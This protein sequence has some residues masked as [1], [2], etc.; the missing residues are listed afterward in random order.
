M[1]D[2][3]KNRFFRSFSSRATQNLQG[4][5]IL[6][7]VG[8][9]GVSGGT[10]LILNYANALKGAGAQVELGYMLGS[11]GDADWHPLSVGLES[12]PLKKYRNEF[13]DLIVFTWWPTVFESKNLSAGQHVYFVQSLE[14]RFALNSS[15]TYSEVKAAGSYTLGLPVIAVS[16]W[17]QNLIASQTGS[18]AWLVKN[19]I[20]KALFPLE[21]PKDR[22]TGKLGIVVEGALGV[23]MKAVQE[24]LEVVDKMTGVSIVHIS[25]EAR[26]G[27]AIA[28]RS[29]ERVPIGK[30]HSIYREFD[31]MLKL[32][33][34]EGMFGPPLEAFHAGLTGVFSRVSG[35]DEYLLHEKNSL[36]VEVDDF[37]DARDQILRL[38]DDS[39]LLQRLKQGAHETAASWPDISESATE[40]VAVCASLLRGKSV[41]AQFEA[42][43]ESFLALFDS[44][45]NDPGSLYGLVPPSLVSK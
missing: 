35:Y 32:S 12:R 4:V 43:R 33:R 41:S 24:T 31:V 7:A 1:N 15:D 38:R 3:W 36:L 14:S 34:V 21:P 30:M 23:P 22:R 16:S 39:N 18:P 6:I 9:L 26:G 44:Q 37:D 27:S 10:N 45:L 11:A 17:L 25:P 5:R 20:D 29:F 19:G 2:Q 40:F 8:S 13:F 42:N 28:E